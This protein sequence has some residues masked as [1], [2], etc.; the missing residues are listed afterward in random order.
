VTTQ[1]HIFVECASNNRDLIRIAHKWQRIHGKRTK[2]YVWVS[3][4]EVWL[5]FDG[6]PIMSMGSH[7]KQGKHDAVP[8]EDYLDRMK[9]HEG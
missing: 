9:A 7:G 4:K 3:K 8:V 1:P 6:Q 5:S 2:V